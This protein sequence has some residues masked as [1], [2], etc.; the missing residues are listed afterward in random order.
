MFKAIY[1][2]EW[3]FIKVMPIA[4]FES[5]PTLKTIHGCFVSYN[6]KMLLLHGHLITSSM[7]FWDI[8]G[9]G[10]LLELMT[11]IGR[12]LLGE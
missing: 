4:F 7:V 10:K 12:S 2:T 8:T 9:V 6:Y 1:K 3:F 5:K 11:L